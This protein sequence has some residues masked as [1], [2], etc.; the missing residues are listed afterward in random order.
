MLNISYSLLIFSFVL[1]FGYFGEILFKKTRI[2][3][4]IFLILIGILFGYLNIVSYSSLLPI[5]SYVAIVTLLLIIFQGGVDLTIEE[6][7]KY[8]W[9]PVLQVI[10]YVGF[11]FFGVTMFLHYVLNLSFIE[12]EIIASIFSGETSTILIIPLSRELKIKRGSVIFLTLESSL[13]SVVLTILFTLLISNSYFTFQTFIY[14]IISSVAIGL[15]IGFLLSIIWI[16]IMNKFELKEYIYALTIGLLVL[17]YVII[18]YLNGNEYIGALVFGSVLGNYKRLDRFLG[19]INM[20]DSLDHVFKFNKELTFLLR[21]FFFF[22]LGI[23]MNILSPHLLYLFSISLVLFGIL[24]LARF[25]AVNISTYKSD[26]RVDK[27]KLFIMM[28]QGLT[29]ITLVALAQSYNLPL[30]SEFAVIIGFLV[31]LTNIF[32]AISLYLLKSSI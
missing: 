23:S 8:S 9:R 3:P 4:F 31:L 5:I 32:S 28:A 7:T 2:S 20:K 29:V 10:L 15:V 12:S 30:I 11:S 25:V 26:F 24:M 19:K 14:S 6:L 13:N 27:D 17:T 16:R 18:Y 21:S 1:L 22:Y